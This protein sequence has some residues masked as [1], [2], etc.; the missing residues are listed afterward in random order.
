VTGPTL[1]GFIWFLQNIVGIPALYLPTDAP[2]I[3]WAYN[4][5]VDTVNPIFQTV[6]SWQMPSTQLIYTQ[7]VYNLGAHDIILWAQD[8]EP[9][10]TP[11]YKVDS[12]GNPIGYFEYMRQ[13]FGLNTLV[14]GVVTATFDQGTGTTLAVPE[15]LKNLTISDLGLLQTPWG[16]VYLGYA[17]AWNRPWGIS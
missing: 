17:Q 4:I 8:V 14:P 6:P 3:S 15:G 11:P 1:T 13:K 7:M 16:R 9:P 10:P 5:V 2:V 12:N